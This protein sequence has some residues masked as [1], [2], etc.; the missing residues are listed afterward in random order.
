MASDPAE[1]MPDDDDE[2]AGNARPAKGLTLIFDVVRRFFAAARNS[3]GNLGRSH[4]RQ[5]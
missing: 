2:D 5:T 3:S 4:R 1:A